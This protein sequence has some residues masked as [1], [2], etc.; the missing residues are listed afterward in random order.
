[1]EKYNGYAVYEAP[2][3]PWQH[4]KY[5]GK[6]PIFSQAVTACENAKANGRICFIKGIKKDGTEIIIL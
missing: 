6:T 3:K 4:G 5:I 2:K 1:M